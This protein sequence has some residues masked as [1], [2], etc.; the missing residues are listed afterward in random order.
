MSRRAF[1]FMP[2]MLL[3]LRVTA[4][5]PTKVPVQILVIEAT[6]E[7]DKFEERLR[8]LKKSLFGGYTGAIVLD[9]L[10]A[11]VDAGASVSLELTKK[12]PAM[13]KVT[14]R[15]VGADG[16]VTL[17]VA[18]EAFAFSANT[19]HKKGNATMVVGTPTGPKTALFLAVTPKSL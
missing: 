4:A 5:P 10:S 16:T 7:N 6:S 12:K 17:T 18:I 19:T 11:E 14:V 8:P 13:L 1:L 3:P 15:G 9:E 2:L